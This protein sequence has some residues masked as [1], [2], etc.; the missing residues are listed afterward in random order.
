MD[1]TD[2]P[3]QEPTPF[4]SCW[5]GHK[6]NSACVHYEVALSVETGRFVWANGPFS[7]GSYSDA[8]I[9]KNGLK[10]QL[11][12]TEFVITDA[13]YGDPRCI[14]PPPPM[15]PMVERYAK[16]R[17]CHETANGRLK[18]FAVLRMKFRHDIALHVHCFFAVLNIV[19]INMAHF[20]LFR[21]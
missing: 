21:I 17:S 13:G 18:K 20:P 16:L 1:G 4:N 10:H 2:C 14:P 8:R 11:G 19:H 12:R 3:I 6:T 15:H 9:F 5:W 7:A